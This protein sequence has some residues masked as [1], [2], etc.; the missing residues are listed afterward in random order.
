MKTIIATCIHPKA[1]ELITENFS[2][3]LSQNAKLSTEPST[4]AGR[5]DLAISH[6]EKPTNGDQRIEHMIRETAF[7]VSTAY[8]DAFHDGAIYGINKMAD[9]LK[10]MQ[11]QQLPVLRLGTCRPSN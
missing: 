3:R 10:K 9:N 4:M 7:L 11:V 5:V 6:G 8:V 1:A 2:V